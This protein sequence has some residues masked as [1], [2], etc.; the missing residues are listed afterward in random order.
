MRPTFRILETPI[1]TRERPS[2]V[3]VDMVV[4]E[5]HVILHPN[6]PGWRDCPQ[7]KQSATARYSGFNHACN[8]CGWVEQRAVSAA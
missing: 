3:H 6:D 4:V 7:C 8:R 1:N 5:R 2:Y